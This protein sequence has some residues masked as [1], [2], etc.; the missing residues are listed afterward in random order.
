MKT[1]LKIIIAILLLFS[2][3]TLA[4]SQNGIYMSLSDYEQNRLSYESTCTREKY[5]HI[6]DFFWS[7]PS[8]TV[9]SAD[10]KYKIKKNA[11]Y[12]YRDCDNDVYRFYN[13]TEYRIAES[14]YIFIYMKEE[15][16][17][18]TKGYKV[19]NTYYFSAT[20]GDEI[21]LLTLE[22]LKKVFR[23]NTKFIELLRQCVCDGSV[24]SY[25][26]VHKTFSINYLYSKT[27]KQ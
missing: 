14:G 10:K 18:Q 21:H 23:D 5:I 15:N 24:C 7:M 19:V 20:A 1:K 13:N 6:H 9:R 3:S 16:I 26:K 2:L 11:I 22:N 4:K 25:D 12:G 8:I 27:I 17:A